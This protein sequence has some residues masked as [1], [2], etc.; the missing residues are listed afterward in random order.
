ML[1]HATIPPSLQ[2]LL[3]HFWPCFTRPTFATFTALLT[4]LITHTGPRTICGMLTG[5]GLARTWPHHRAH[6]FFSHR[7]WDPHH[8]GL[9]MAR[10]I[11]GTCTAPGQEIT[12]AVDDTLIKRSGSQIHHRYRHH[13][14]AR[15]KRDPL[16]WGVC[17]VVTALTVRLPGR[18]RSLA[19]PTLVSCWRP[20]RAKRPTGR[21][22]RQG[23]APHRDTVHANAA[24]R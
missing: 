19:L 23:R 9:T 14:G 15:P 18:T 1:P 4:G 2:R 11:A 12:L 7:R 16:A 21:A 10:L 17:Y 5:A 8:L 24:S 6:A 20:N 3:N 13:D 22:R